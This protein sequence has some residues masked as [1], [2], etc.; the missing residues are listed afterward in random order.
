MQHAL[1]RRQYL[2]KSLSG[3]QCCS[4]HDCQQSFRRRLHRMRTLP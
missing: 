1:F 4:R 2:G 3:S